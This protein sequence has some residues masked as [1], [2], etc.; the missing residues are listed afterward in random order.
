V[1]RRHYN[2]QHRVLI[3]FLIL[4]GLSDGIAHIKGLLPPVGPFLDS[5]FVFDKKLTF[6]Y[7]GFFV[8]EVLGAALLRQICGLGRIGL[9][10]DAFVPYN[11]IDSKSV[12]IITHWHLTEVE[13]L[14]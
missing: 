2:D 5:V 11:Q 6:R 10:L 8:R 4:V 14:S 13:H 3:V 1:N 7:P 9:G 12:V